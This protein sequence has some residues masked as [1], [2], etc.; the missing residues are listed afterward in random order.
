L[1]EALDRVAFGDHVPLGLAEA[2]P[3]VDAAKPFAERRR[4]GLL[5]AQIDRGLN[6]QAVL[7]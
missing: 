2:S 5:Q 7:V 1:P 6:R 4:C 3:L